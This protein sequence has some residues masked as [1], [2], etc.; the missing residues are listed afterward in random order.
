MEKENKASADKTTEDK[1]AAE[2]AAAEK[3]AQTT[4]ETV[5]ARHSIKAGGKLHPPG[6]SITLPAREARRLIAQGAVAPDEGSR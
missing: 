3:R 4:Q 5:T 1:A 2:K 6:S